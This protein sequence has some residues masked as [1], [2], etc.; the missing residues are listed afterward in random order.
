MATEVEKLRALLADIKEGQSRVAFDGF[1]EYLLHPDHLFRINAALA[2]PVRECENCVTLR[3][4][5]LDAVEELVPLRAQTKRLKSLY[6]DARADGWRDG[7]KAMRAQA[8]GCAAERARYW[9]ETSASEGG[10]PMLDD[11]AEEARYIADDIRGLLMPEDK[12]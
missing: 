9:A 10:V 8:S 12:P 2:E 1:T 6:L 7:A 5:Y 3:G 4:Q 11:R